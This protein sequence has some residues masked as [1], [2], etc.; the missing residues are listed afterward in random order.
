MKTNP[1]NI[2]KSNDF[3]DEQ[4]IDYWVDISGMQSFYNTIKPNSPASM[5]ILG[6]KGSGKTHLM[7]YYSFNVRK[8]TYKNKFISKISQDGYLGIYLR[9]KGIDSKKFEGKGQE[10]YAWES[11]FSYYFDLW[12][13]ITLLSTL[14]EII[15][16]S[17]KD[18]IDEEA[19]C[20]DILS[21]FDVDLKNEKESI[22]NINEL[23]NYFVSLQK[24]I[25]YISNNC[26]MTRSIAAIDIKSSPGK[27]IFGI[28]IVFTEYIPS[29]KNIL[30][31]HLIDELESFT[32]SQQ[33]YINAL[34]RDRQ[35]PC[36][37]KI[38]SRLY[39]IKTK[40]T[41]SAGEENKEGSEIETVILDR[42]LRENPNYNDFA[43]RLIANRL[44]NNI[45]ELKDL[46]EDIKEYLKQSYEEIP[47]SAHYQKY[48]EFIW[49]KYPDPTLR[50]YWTKLESRLNGYF[51]GKVDFKLVYKYLSCEEFPLLEKINIFTLYKDFNS[52]DKVARLT[53]CCKKIAKEC[54]EYIEKNKKKDRYN[55]QVNHFA[56]DMLAQILK[57]SEHS[58]RYLGI[59][60]FIKMSDGLP[61][62][63]LTILKNI[64]KWTFYNEETPYRGKSISIKTQQDGV[65]ESAEWFFKDARIAGSDGKLIRDSI[66]RL[67]TFFKEVRFSDKPS[68][69]SLVAFSVDLTKVSVETERIIDLAEKWSLLINIEG[70][71]YDKNSSRKDAKYQLNPML[72]PRWDLPIARRGAISL[73]HN[74]VDSIF[75]T[76]K[77]NKFEQLL[78]D[79][80][81]LMFFPFSRSNKSKRK[82]KNDDSVKRTQKISHKQPDLPGLCSND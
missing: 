67:A 42:E 6:G 43:I 3:S 51:K 16:E 27:L 58:Q 40:E 48:C 28:P 57:D 19:I 9:T 63:L 64:H 1:F 72:A 78:K 15:E 20:I 18:T 44:E 54:K 49:S 50:P 8:H 35:A 76:S 10:A 24:E 11:I 13:S 59:T 36:S 52:I 47:K 68:E 65:L 79:R 82:F 77:T 12:V 62:N 70:G 7:R 73:S 80:T 66:E 56:Q 5:F 26:A 21:L 17:S 4:I 14:S 34:V 38:G 53:N 55:D 69:C 61:R 32:E 41:F 71:Q 75:D 74:I 23:T 25:D 81:K 33:Q 39:G 30:F 60:T 45:P 37:F 29:F 2:T 31:M 22:K 46:N